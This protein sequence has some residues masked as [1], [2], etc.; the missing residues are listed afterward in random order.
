M[1]D[2]KAKPDGRGHDEPGLGPGHGGGPTY[3]LDLEGVVKD[4]HEPTITV[5]QI[6]DLAGWAGDQQV[7][8]VDMATND[9]V[10]LTEDAT[11]ELKPGLGFAKK[12]KFKRGRRDR[13]GL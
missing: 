9:E 12:I 2:E 1:Q 11:V 5:P 7:V 8:V 3:K 13:M 6:R 10:A 4:W